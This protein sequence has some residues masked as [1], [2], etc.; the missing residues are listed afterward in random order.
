MKSKSVLP[1]LRLQRENSTASSPRLG[2]VSHFFVLTGMTVL[3]L[4][5]ASA[6]PA[7]AAIPPKPIVFVQA[8]KLIEL[9]ESLTYP[10]RV[11]PRIKASV[12][13]EADGVVTKIIAPLGRQVK[14]KGAVLVIK[15]TD[16]VYQYAP[17]VV[18]SPVSGIVSKVEVTE[19]SRVA[20]GD[21]LVLVTEPSQVNVVV[22]IPAQDVRSIQAG[23]LAELKIPGDSFHEPVI[24]KVKGL[25]PFVDPATG[26][27]SC[28]LELAKAKDGSKSLPPAGAIARVTFKVNVRNGFSVPDSSITYRGKDPFVRVVQ[29]GKAK[30]M[31]IVIGRKQAGFIE[32]LKGLR[33]GDQ[34]VERTSGFIS[35]GEAVEVQ[36]ADVPPAAK[37]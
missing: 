33:P 3:T 14:A 22:E 21:K 10:A 30:L 7:A 8:I 16:P 25:S 2:I 35:D 28:E 15:N 36:H 31:P 27:A 17:M 20:R 4:I 19:G 5:A 13:A 18:I 1:P 37:S 24:L 12:T 6:L 11:E 34:I 23:Q 26:T 29:D 32:I 9:S